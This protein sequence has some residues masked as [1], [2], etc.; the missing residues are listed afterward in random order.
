M[1]FGVAQ[2]RGITAVSGCVCQLGAA[3][4]CVRTL[5]GACISAAIHLRYNLKM[6]AGLSDD[7]L[8]H[9]AEHGEL[10]L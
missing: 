8:A 7:Q 3:C 5:L 10:F 2:I 6:F 1:D 4:A 9:F